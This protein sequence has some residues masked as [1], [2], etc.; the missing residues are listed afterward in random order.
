MDVSDMKFRFTPQEQ[1]VT[2]VEIHGYDNK[3]FQGT[4]QNAFYQEKKRFSNLTQ[5]LFLMEQLQDDIHYP[6]K[7][8]E[9][10]RF[11]P[12]APTVESDAL[13]DGGAEKTLATFKVQILFRQNASWQGNVTWVEKG[14]DSQFRSVLELVSLMDSVL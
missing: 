11:K 8:M 9:T 12:E 4:L 1:K 14:M 5:L 7:G 10:R 6:Q 3:N 13:P 2:M